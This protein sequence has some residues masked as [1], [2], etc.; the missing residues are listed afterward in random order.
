MAERMATLLLLAALA[1]AAGAD[2]VAGVTSLRLENGLRVLVQPMPD[3]PL[4]HL[5][6][7][8]GAGSHLDPAEHAGLAH[9]VEHL[10]FTSSRGYP[11]G[12]L[13]RE[14][15]LHT[16]R[17]NAATSHTYMMTECVCLPRFLPEV[18]AVEV[19]RLAGLE[20]LPEEFAR[21]REVVL[22]E[23]AWRGRTLPN[24]DLRD[25]VFEAAYA[26]S[27]FARP[28]GGAPE[29]IGAATPADAE[30]FRRRWLRPDN[31]VVVLTGAVDSVTTVGLV[32]A[33]LGRLARGGG[34]D[35]VPDLPAFLPAATSPVTTVLDRYDTDG[36]R[37]CLGFRLSAASAEE[38]PAIW[39]LRELLRR[40]GLG[41]SLRSL[42]GEF[43]LTAE[44]GY[45]FP[46][47]DG[48]VH[49][50]DA[51]REVA[52]EGL[53]S[54]WSR[55]EQARILLRDAKSVASIRRS[56]R[57]SIA[58]DVRDPDAVARTQGESVLA[59]WP[60]VDYNATAGAVD[61]LRA[62]DVAARFDAALVPGKATVG[63][64][65]GRDSGRRAKVD[66]PKRRDDATS[67]EAADPLASVGEAEISA[68]LEA[69]AADLHLTF[70]ARSL[71]NGIPVTL[72]PAPGGA[73][74][75]VRGVARMPWLVSEKR[76]ERAGLIQLYNQV[77]NAGFHSPRP[78]GN[79]RR[80]S[81]EPPYQ[82]QVA[83]DPWS[84]GFSAEGPAADLDAIG[85]SLVERLDDDEFSVAHWSDALAKAPARFAA[86]AEQPDN[87]ATVYRWSTLLGADHPALGIWQ[88][89]ATAAR[90]L[91]YKDLQKLHREVSGCRTLELVVVGAADPESVVSALSASFGR[92]DRYKKMSP[93]VLP[94]RA[95]GVSGRIVP[96]FDQLDVALTLTFGPAAASPPA[97]GLEL[98]LMT[99][100]VRARLHGRLRSE[101]GRTYGVA[102]VARPMSGFVLTE[103]GASC[104]PAAAPAMLASL[105]GELESLV[106][107]GPTRAEMAR[108]QLAVCQRIVAAFAAADAAAD[109]LQSLLMA[110]SLTDAPLA[111][112]ND[113]TMKRLRELIACHLTPDSFAFSAVGPVF[114][115]DLG[116]YLRP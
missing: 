109:L 5:K 67:G 44:A 25:A 78:D 79:G 16:V 101:M 6:V 3:I 29:S 99:E 50:A 88:G 23:I 92:R 8:Y 89:D 84:L 12:G 82:A 56:L 72:L 54:V 107:P 60:V 68:V 49:S 66:L 11:Q 10:L 33:T 48:W 65:Y 59:G 104:L 2:D 81:F 17:S 106:D 94:P 74:V 93:S 7:Y 73:R 98:N 69:Y 20:P 34:V 90:G 112:L 100:L 28:I 31:A 97:T 95:P 111:A 103:I 27:P 83:A 85:R 61:D 21:E 62:A 58:R 46:S 80:R 52:Q 57:T 102:V 15:A 75:L 35:L 37:V 36:F 26:G 43:F 63:I 116:R 40:Q 24:A 77:V 87:V 1:S 38:R 13:R 64:L 115:D 110:G 41:T 18:L 55:I 4:V 96:A 113:M 22:A 71:P 53:A 45:R 70:A 51:A 114:E 30:A 42:P 39:F 9:L 32:E 91:R 76:G 14:L 19:D 47:E 108:A 105:R 86:Q